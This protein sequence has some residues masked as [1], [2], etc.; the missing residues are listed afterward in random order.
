M[1]D[2]STPKLVNAFGYK[3][4]IANYIKPTKRPMS[5]MS[6]II[7]VDRNNTV[8]LVVGASGGSRII[9]STAQVISA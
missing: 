2:F 1:D 5:S 3:P 6:P 4:S 8:R 7:V 9:S